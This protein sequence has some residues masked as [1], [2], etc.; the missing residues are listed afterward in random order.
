M[1]MECMH[2]SYLPAIS[3]DPPCDPLWCEN[4]VSTAENRQKF[5]DSSIEF[6]RT[7]GFDG[8]D[9]DWEYPGFLVARARFPDGWV[10]LELISWYH[11]DSGYIGRGGRVEDKAGCPRPDLSLCLCAGVASGKGS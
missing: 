10:R 7:W 3:V 2:V 1:Y 11:G 8:L 4:M 6:C 5:V 9:L